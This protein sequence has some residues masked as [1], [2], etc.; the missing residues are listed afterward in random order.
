MS[1]PIENK[2]WSSEFNEALLSLNKLIDRFDT[3]LK[4]L[5]VR[6]DYQEQ[7]NLGMK[8][9][10]PHPRSKLF[11]W[12]LEFVSTYTAAYWDIA[13]VSTDK[14]LLYLRNKYPNN[15]FIDVFDQLSLTKL[16]GFEFD[17]I[18][19]DVSENLF[20]LIIII[21]F[22]DFRNESDLRQR[23]EYVKKFYNFLQME[24]PD[25]L[26][27]L[28]SHWE[29][30]FGDIEIVKKD[31]AKRSN[32]SVLIGCD[33]TTKSSYSGVIKLYQKICKTTGS[34]VF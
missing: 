5:S 6:L 28:A 21:D 1:N 13:T 23:D 27:I 29:K 17:G 26:T 8:E 16:K 14:A 19:Y 3:S 18:I 4:K 34:P 2:L 24:R 12:D 20:Y 10:R 33:E 31:I 30:F 15:V 32:V 11:H 22:R 9:E 25:S 7:F